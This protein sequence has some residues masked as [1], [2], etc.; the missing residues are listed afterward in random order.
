MLHN[1][2]LDLQSPLKGVSYG[3]IFLISFVNWRSGNNIDTYKIRKVSEFLLKRKISKK[4]GAGLFSESSTI[5][6]L[7]VKYGPVDFRKK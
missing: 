7:I 6:Y 5:Q 3:P 2:S 4:I 1:L